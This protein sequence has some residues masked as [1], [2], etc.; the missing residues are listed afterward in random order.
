VIPASLLTAAAATA[1]STINNTGEFLIVQ[2][3]YHPTQIDL[4]VLVL[5]YTVDEYMNLKQFLGTSQDSDENLIGQV[6]RIATSEEKL[7]LPLKHERELIT[8]AIA[9]KIVKKYNLKMNVYGAEY[10]FDSQLLFI[11]YTAES[12]IDYRGF[13]RD[14]TRE[15]NNIT[16]KMKKTNQCRKFI[17]NNKAAQALNTG[18]SIQL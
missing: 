5:M 16:V 9:K 3:H 1:T 8:L 4:G 17:P 14:M 10:Q 7:Y 13:V 18:E 11:Y 2:S 15:C 12:R 6:L